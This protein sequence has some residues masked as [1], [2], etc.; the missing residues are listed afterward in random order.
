MAIE[1]QLVG[2]VH[3]IEGIGTPA[4]VESFTVRKKN[5]QSKISREREGRQDQTPIFRNE[6]PQRDVNYRTQTPEKTDRMCE[7]NQRQEQNGGDP[8]PCPAM[9]ECR[10]RKAR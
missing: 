6:P 4:R 1:N 9:P 7:Q 10:Q 5:A 3:P 2:T 8:I